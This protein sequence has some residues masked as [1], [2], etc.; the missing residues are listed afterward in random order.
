MKISRLFRSKKSK[1]NDE[2]RI[3]E[4]N[5]IR[6]GFFD[7]FFGN[8][9]VEYLKLFSII[10]LLIASI[11]MFNYKPSPVIRRVNRTEVTNNKTRITAVDDNPYGFHPFYQVHKRVQYK[12]PTINPCRGIDGHRTILL[13]LLSRA[14]NAHIREAIRHSWG[15]VRVINDIE[16]RTTFIVGVDDGMIK[17]IEIEQSIYH[18]KFSLFKIEINRSVFLHSIRCHTSEFT[19]KLSCRL[20]QRISCNL[21][22]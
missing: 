7:N 2:D 3:D 13:A 21:L 9:P 16:I 20:L 11:I 6:C 22:E 10:I 5:V 14:S 17:Q 19:R 15:G 18:G 12:N 4:D 8:I 1:W